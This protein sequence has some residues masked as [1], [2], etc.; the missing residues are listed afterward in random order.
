M[1]SF[2][3]SLLSPTEDEGLWVNAPKVLMH[4]FL[5]FNQTVAIRRQAL[6][7]VGGFDETLRYLEDY[8]LALRLSLLGPFAF[9][10]ESL[11]VYRLGFA[12]SLSVEAQKEKLTIKENAVKILERVSQILEERDEYVQL[13]LPMRRALRK[14]Q[15]SL[16]MAQLGQ[17]RTL[18]AHLLSRFLERAEHYCGAAADRSP[19]F[20][21]MK[22]L[23]PVA[24]A[25]GLPFAD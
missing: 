15:R 20:L 1:S 18:R 11:T 14:A 16:W 5:L 6:E 3:N 9:I 24:K 8:D 2:H 21:P 19:W 17:K 4:R 23:P 22:T 13:R 12:G 25:T 10:R 7:N